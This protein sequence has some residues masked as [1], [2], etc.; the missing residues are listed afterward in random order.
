MTSPNEFSARATQLLLAVAARRSGSAEAYDTLL[1]PVVFTAVKKRG[2]LLVR[3]AAQMTGT[4]GLPVPFVPDCDLE[5]V[6]HDV[7]VHA[8]DRARATAA[9][10]DPARGDGATWALRQA[11][12]SYVDVVRTSY[13]GRR[14]MTVVPTE[15]EQLAAA[16]HRTH[17][18]AD[19]AVLVEQRAALDAALASLPQAERFVVLATMHQGLTYAETAE[20]LLGDANQVRRVDKLLQSARR[21]LT[22]A[23]QAWR[24]ERSGV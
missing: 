14:A 10:F 5:W 17:A 21:R 3:Q 6:A 1:Y 2:R 4:G 11:A 23:E 18:V 24:A 13:G 12:F 20:L 9:R 19:P 22:V 16:A 15:D 7:A 8:L